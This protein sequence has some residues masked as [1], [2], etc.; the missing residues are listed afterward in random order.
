[1]AASSL[2]SVRGKTWW[3]EAKRVFML[4]LDL[5][6]A[7]IETTRALKSIPNGVIALVMVMPAVIA[8]H[9]L[10]VGA[11]TMDFDSTVMA[12][13]GFRRF[14]EERMAW[15]A[16]IA[17]LA[18]SLQMLGVSF[19]FFSTAIEMLG[20]RFSQFNLPSWRAITVASII[21]DAVTD[22]ERVNYFLVPLWG[23][24]TN[25]A[26]GLFGVILGGPG[27][28]MMAIFWVFCWVTTLVASSYYL[29]L[30]FVVAVWSV[31]GLLFKSI[32]YWVLGWLAGKGWIAK[33]NETGGFSDA[34]VSGGRTAASRPGPKAQAPRSGGDPRR[35][36]GPSP[37]NAPPR[38]GPRW[39]P[40]DL[41]DDDLDDEE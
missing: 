17:F 35:G 9:A 7:L 21:F 14:A 19:A 25:N 4:S 26:E 10:F 8:A 38:G 3:S 24:W 39:P 12:T 37:R 30:L 20:S 29:E 16:G 41:D 31:V 28:W 36:G 22:T 5:S 33:M 6:E 15:M 32:G 11:Y 34:A 2:Y 13:E 18:W 40:V 23:P 1:M 27:V